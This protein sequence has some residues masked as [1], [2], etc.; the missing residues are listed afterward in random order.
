MAQTTN[1]QVTGWVGWIY[2]AGFL[3]LLE[4]FFQIIAGLV[5]LLN[6][7]F[8]TV[9]KDTLVVFDVTTW[10]W[11]HLI[12]GLAIVAVGT[13]IFSGHLWARVVAII[14]VTLNILA[15]FTFVSAYPIWSTFSIIVGVLVVYALTVHGGET[16]LE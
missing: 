13:S 14:L 11:I 1:K 4:G 2:F 7:E 12:L 16:E 10:G 6:D 9:V 8:Y 3:L 15:Q 5:A